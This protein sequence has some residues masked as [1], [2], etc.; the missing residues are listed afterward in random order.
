MITH[1]AGDYVALSSQTIVAAAV[2][3]I[4]CAALLVTAFSASRASVRTKRKDTLEA[5]IKWSDDAREAR[6]YVTRVLGEELTKPRMSKLNGMV[7]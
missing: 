5:W 6:R 1:G 3:A 2:A 7:S 4:V